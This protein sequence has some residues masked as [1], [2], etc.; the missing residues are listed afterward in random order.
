MG[1]KL[2]IKGADF[3][4]NGISGGDEP[5]YVTTYQGVLNSVDAGHVGAI[6]PTSSGIYSKRVF[7]S[8]T[9][10]VPAGETVGFR[11]S[12]GLTIQVGGLLVYNSPLVFVPA[13][14]ERNDTY[15]QY[16]ISGTPYP[17][18]PPSLNSFTYTNS[19]A[20]TVYLGLTLRKD[21]NTAFSPSDI[22]SIEVTLQ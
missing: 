4:A 21:D 6:D 14:T 7:T 19:S 5:E 20:S 10:A 1:K 2:I 13:T 22:G 16:C 15:V 9:I 17:S 18:N 3:S 11:Q 8:R 12:S